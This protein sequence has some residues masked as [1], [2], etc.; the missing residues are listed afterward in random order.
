MSMGM[1][2][3]TPSVMSEVNDDPC[4]DEERI[5]IVLRGPDSEE[6]MSV[7]P[8]HE[9]TST[10]FHEIGTPDI[11][12][13]DEEVPEGFSFEDLGIGDGARLDYVPWSI[14]QKLDYIKVNRCRFVHNEH[15]R[16]W[17]LEEYN[18]K[19]CLD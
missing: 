12:L 16:E 8:Q 18:A 13:G 5:I 4:E 11:S 14:K 19:T 1:I 10:I 17:A 2:L 6:E 7:C 3:L 9:V 15:E